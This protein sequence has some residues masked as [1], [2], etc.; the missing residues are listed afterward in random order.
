MKAFGRY[1]LTREPRVLGAPDGDAEHPGGGAL[2]GATLL[3]RNVREDALGE[4]H[5]EER[6]RGRCE[7]ANAVQSV[8]ARNRGGASAK[9]VTVAR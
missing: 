7:T 5:D 4:R 1:Q 2:G 9:R 3:D 8:S 6:P